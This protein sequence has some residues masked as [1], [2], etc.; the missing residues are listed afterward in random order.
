MMT[1]EEFPTSDCLSHLPGQASGNSGGGNAH[2]NSPSSCT[3]T[4]IF[5]RSPL[6]TFFHSFEL[7]CEHQETV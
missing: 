3:V 6:L 5:S 1:T 7:G 4:P 2:Q